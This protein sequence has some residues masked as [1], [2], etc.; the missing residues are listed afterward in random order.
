MKWSKVP[1]DQVEVG[2][3]QD[4]S[5]ECEAIGSPQPSVEWFKHSSGL[6]DNRSSSGVGANGK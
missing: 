2:I 5:L 4:V 3:N 6:A 1:K